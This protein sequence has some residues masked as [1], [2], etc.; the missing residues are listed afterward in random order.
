M[1]Y[2]TPEIEEFHEGFEYESQ[3]IAADLMGI[4][5]K[6]GT[7]SDGQLGAYLSDE[8]KRGEVR[9]KCL[10]KEDV[11]SL[12]WETSRKYIDIEDNFTIRGNFDRVFLLTLLTY[13]TV[14]DYVKIHTE[15][16]EKE[17]FAGFIKN[18][19]ELNRLMKQL[20]IKK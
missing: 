9:V 20:E 1:K 6:K 5:W 17:V 2:Y 15:D 14:E 4:E 7:Y 3:D 8:I 16:Y 13:N 12:G 10:D 19:S 18:K 11:L